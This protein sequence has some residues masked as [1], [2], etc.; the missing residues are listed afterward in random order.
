MFALL[1][2]K[3]NILALVFPVRLEINPFKPIHLASVDWANKVCLNALSVVG[4]A[5]AELEIFRASDASELKFLE[6][7]HDNAVWFFAGIELRI[8]TGTGLITFFSI[9]K[10]YLNACMTV[11]LGAS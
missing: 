2:R 1:A 3:S 8:A 10:K 7:F 4:K 11:D 5:L 9:R 6:L